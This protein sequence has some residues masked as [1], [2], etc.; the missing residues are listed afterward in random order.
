[1][2]LI[3]WYKMGGRTIQGDTDVCLQGF[4]SAV[5]E[6]CVNIKKGDFAVREGTREFDC[7]T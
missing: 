4:Q 5:D 6:H 2:E 3:V 1:M 7:R